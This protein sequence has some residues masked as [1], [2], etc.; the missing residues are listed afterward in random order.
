MINFT[1]NDNYYHLQVHGVTMGTKVAP[2]IANLFLKLGLFEANA[3]AKAPFKPRI[4]L[5]YIYDIFMI[6]TEGLD[7]LKQ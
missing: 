6:W 5:R 2:S 3:F 4:W 1:F 7:N